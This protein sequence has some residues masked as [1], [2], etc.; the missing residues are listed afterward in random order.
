MHILYFFFTFSL[1]DFQ[2]KYIIS[3]DSGLKMT[4]V[5]PERVCFLPP[6]ERPNL[7][8]NLQ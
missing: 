4:A 2:S 5:H 3:E 6:V 7:T 8:N 1:D